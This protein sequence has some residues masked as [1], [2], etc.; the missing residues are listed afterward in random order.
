MVL[1]G[2]ERKTFVAGA[3][4]CKAGWVVVSQGPHGRLE[5]NVVPHFSQLIDREHWLL[6]VISQLAF[7]IMARVRLTK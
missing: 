1:R 5:V 3:D 2:A 7:P 6:V 4:G